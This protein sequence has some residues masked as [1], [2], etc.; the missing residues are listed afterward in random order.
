M[1]QPA[2][3][4]VLHAAAD[5][6][7]AQLASCFLSHEG[8]T[9]E[10]CFNDWLATYPQVFAT[11]ITLPLTPDRIQLHT[12]GSRVVI[13]ILRDNAGALTIATVDRRDGTLR[14]AELRSRNPTAVLLSIPD[15]VALFDH[16]GN[17]ID[18]A[19]EPYIVAL[20]GAFNAA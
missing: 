7:A 9:R 16:A 13:N 5:N 11:R 2:Y 10:A 4:D 14:A 6:G 19:T 1:H 17:E 3:L 20:P 12:A 8:R 15:D 18:R